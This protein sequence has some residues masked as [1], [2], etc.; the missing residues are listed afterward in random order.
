MKM[1]L[2]L[3][4]LLKSRFNKMNVILNFRLP[5]LQT[6]ILNFILNSFPDRFRIRL[7]FS[8]CHSEPVPVSEKSLT[9]RIFI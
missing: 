9:K 5:E 3:K 1:L 2:A 8:Y 7:D 4:W 6:V